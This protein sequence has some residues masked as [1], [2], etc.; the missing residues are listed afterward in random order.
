MRIGKRA[1]L[2]LL[3]STPVMAGFLTGCGD[4][5]QAPNNTS[6]TGFSLSNAG[7]ITVAAGSSGTSVITVTPGSSFTGTVALSCAVTTSLS[8]PVSLPTCSFSSSSLTFSSASAQTATLTATT[9]ATTALGAYQVA[10]TGI[11]GNVA[12]STT[13]CLEVS[14]SSGNCTAT[15]STSGNFYILTND[16]IAG[17]SINAGVLTALSGSSYTVTTASAIVIA[18]SGAF[19]YVAS[20]VGIT[21]YTIDSSTGALTQ[22][23]GVN[24]VFPDTVA[25]AIQVDPSGQWLL[26]AS[27]LGTLYAYPIT[28]SGTLD[29]T[30]AIQS[31]GL[32][33]EAAVQKGGIAVSATL[34]SV[35]LGS[36]G[37]ESFPF[38]ANSST[39]VGTPYTPI[40]KPFGSSGAAISVAIDP[41]NR[42][43]Y[44]GEVAAFPSSTSNSGAL[45]VFAIGAGAPTELTYT[46][47]YAPAGTGPHAI[48]PDPTGD[49]LYVASGQTDTTGVI[50]GYSVSSS[51]LTALSATVA[52]GTSPMSLAEDNTDS[53]VVVVNNQGTV[54]VDAYTFDANTTGQLDASTLTGSAGANP[55][56]IVAAPK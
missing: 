36:V 50:T 47:P 55:I 2:L 26:D 56:A 43:L 7:N 4:F 17:Y 46:A 28:S 12:E 38:D 40:A 8:T 51:A 23:T 9:T 48:L 29:S 34:V 10:V 32:A 21:L 53:F 44:I 49:F 3:L 30:R 15:A 20:N 35:P 22:A 11:S 37:T 14:N 24:G 41:Q 1:T 13:V 27:S 52:T 19:L 25:G 33:N 16:S 45:R 39:P 42:L 5:W 6:T 31:L 18:P 54:P